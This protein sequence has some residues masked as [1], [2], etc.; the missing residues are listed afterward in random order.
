[1][2]QTKRES[3]ITA[4]YE[5]LSRD[6]DSAGESNSIQNQK[7]YLEDYARQHGFTNIRHY[8]DDGYT[9]TNFNRPG[10]M[11]MLADIDAGLISTV[12]VKDMS[13]FGR[14][15]LEVGLYTEIH[16]PEKGVRFI[17]INSNVDSDNPTEN[18]FTPFLN[19]INEWYAKDTSRKICAIFK[20]RMSEGL[21][22]SGSVPYG[23]IRLPGDKQTLVADEEAAGVVRRIFEM[24]A[25]G[26]NA[27][28]IARVLTEK[29]VLIPSA[30]ASKYHPEAVHSRSYTDPCLWSPHA[31]RTIL[32]REE[33][34]GHTIL[35]KSVRV[36][37]RSKK[38]RPT[39]RD[40]R[41]FFPDTHEAIID[42]DI[43]D[44]AQKLR[45]RCTRRRP[46]GTHTHMLFVLAF[47]PDCGAKL[48][49]IRN[50]TN[51]A[52][53]NYSFRC[54]HYKSIY[55]ECSSHSISA[56]ALTEAIRLALKVV[57]AE[58]LE[59]E[60]TFR[61]KLNQQWAEQHSN[62]LNESKR[63][64]AAARKRIAELD[65]LIRGL[66]EDRQLGHMPA[67]QVDRLIAQYDQEQEEL[68]SKISSLEAKIEDTKSGR[69][70][71]DRFLRAIRKYRE[72]DELTQD[73]VFELID[74]VDVHQAEDN[75]E[76]G[77]RTQQIDI[78]FSFIGS[79]QPAPEAVAFEIA[80]TRARKAAE[81]AERKRNQ[82]EQ[83]KQR[84]KERKAQRRAELAE[85]AEH[86]PEVAA[87]LAAEKE[88]RRAYNQA[89]QQKRQEKKKQ[90]AIANGT[91]VPPNPFLSMSQKEL[92]QIADSDP[93]AAADPE[94][95]QELKAKNAAAHARVKAKMDDLAERA[96]TD[97]EAARELEEKIARRRGYGRAFAERQKQRATTD[98]ELAAEY[99]AKQR[100]KQRKN[101]ER[102][103]QLRADLRR[104]AETDPAAAEKLAAERAKQVE[105]TTRS[106]RKLNEAA[107]TDPVAAAKR[108]Q[109]LAHRREYY[110]AHKPSAQQA[111]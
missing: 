25:Q 60:E 94:F 23:Y 50:K 101:N 78:T 84:E 30:Y 40:E 107:L 92:A 1:M 11:Q 79:Y 70:D 96:K 44:Q 110:A 73:M 17:A 18:E 88:K 104:K 58:A 36:N 77:E 5:R 64:L 108:G 21:R 67:R 76:T 32:D 71:P 52:Y 57:A 20:S 16:F 98:P 95:A 28:G 69:S 9:G 90:E 39:T 15:Y 80:Q 93:A 43:W 6:D 55:Q 7:R 2:N 63:E 83:S 100:E 41:L 68:E 14:N 13:R 97:P 47:C 31:I 89:Y 81:K 86:D 35:G 3:G 24:A 103:K 19:V 87:K 51:G 49:L 75:A 59:D 26:M 61:T 33:Y 91:Y 105:V 29:R 34:L 99:E 85:Q 65:N 56:T 106:R 62:E 22:C 46:S 102:Q 82:N 53:Y 8:S 4:L 111:V 27:P 54:R 12:I 10:F 37:F 66:Y 45:K 72:F 74:R 48:A 109:H 42:Q 38:R